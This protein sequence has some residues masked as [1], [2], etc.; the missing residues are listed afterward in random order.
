LLEI[1]TG[2]LAGLSAINSAVSTLREGSDNVRDLSSM[3][4]KLSG[5]DETLNDV[6]LKKA[7]IL[8]QRTAF[9][10]VLARKKMEANREAIRSHLLMSGN[11][12]IWNEYI[13][14][15]EEGKRTH[16]KLLNQKKLAA[17]KRKELIQEVGA[18]LVLGSIF[19]GIIMMVIYI[20]AR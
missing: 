20:I 17:K 2:V 16:Q 12:A 13:A 14:I 11:M 1:V 10:L 15:Q 3:L 19:V 7:G 4:Q 9:N 6:E 8:D 18:L 5:M